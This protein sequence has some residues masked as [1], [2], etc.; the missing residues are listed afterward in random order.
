MPGRNNFQKNNYKAMK[1]VIAGDGHGTHYLNAPVT[2]ER[3]LSNL[4]ESKCIT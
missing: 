2:E 4:K 1:H 3:S